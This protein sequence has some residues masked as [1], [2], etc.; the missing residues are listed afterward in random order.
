MTARLAE[1]ATRT[2]VR[3]FGF[4]SSNHVMGGYKD[5]AIAQS[6]G[7]HDRLAPAGWNADPHT[8]QQVPHPPRGIL[9]HLASDDIALSLAELPQ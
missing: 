6:E 5:T 7:S 2:G 9:Q 4:A 3:R 1:A 8:S